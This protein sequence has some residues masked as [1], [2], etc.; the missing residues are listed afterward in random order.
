MFKRTFLAFC[1]I[2]LLSACSG[3]EAAMPPQAVTVTPP[4]E[5]RNVMAQATLP[6]AVPQTIIDQA[7]AEYALLTNVYERVAPSVV[8]ID[9]TGKTP[10]TD[11]R[12][13]GFVFDMD[14]HIVT[15]AHVAADASSIDVTFNDGYVASAKVVGVDAFADLAVIQVSVDKSHLHPVLFADSDR[16]KVGERAIAIGNPFG[17]ASS[18]TVGIVSGLGRQL[19]SAQL[20]SANAPPGFNNPSI[21]QVDTDINPGNSGGPLLNSHGEVIGINTAIRTDTGVFSGVGFAVPAKTIQRVVPQLIQNGKM[22][23][24]W[25]GINS[26]PTEEGLGVQALAEP[27]QLPV[28]AGVL[29]E[30]VIP[31]SPAAKAGLKGGSHPTTVRGKPVCSGGDIIVAV[32]GVF[33]QNMDELLSYLVL[34][35]APGDTLKLL[36]VRGPDTFELP[37]KLE[38]RPTDSLADAPACGK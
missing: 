6:T 16:L 5:I 36:V 18:M 20:V 28:K 27:L 12:A 38:A 23:Y 21:I 22:E 7:D 4:S 32:N 11:G 10:N 2:S 9:M 37:V 24:A 34:N 1:V 25:L 26:L 3:R 29:I 35:G 14:G 15:N 17:L 13:S 8:N 19:P 30:S 31:D 33:I